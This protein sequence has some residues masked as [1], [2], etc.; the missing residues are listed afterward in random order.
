[1][2]VS[3]QEM[4]MS[5]VTISIRIKIGIRVNRSTVSASVLEYLPQY[6]PVAEI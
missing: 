6:P 5:N 4:N 1:M 3:I 2:T